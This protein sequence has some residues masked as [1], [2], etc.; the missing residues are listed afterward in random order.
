MAPPPETSCATS[1]CS[2]ASPEERERHGSNRSPTSSTRPPTSSSLSSAVPASRPSRRI[3][4]CCRVR[5]QDRRGV[6]GPRGMTCTATN[7]SALSVTPRQ[8][9]GPEAQSG[10]RLTAARTLPGRQAEG[11]HIN[12]SGATRVTLPIGRAWR[13]IGGYRA[14]GDALRS[15]SVCRNA[16]TLARRRCGYVRLPEAAGRRDLGPGPGMAVRG[17]LRT[18]SQMRAPGR[19]T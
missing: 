6:A 10:A 13:H 2:R 17:Q 11:A 7:P 19:P 4:R 18:S 9:R 12:H 3:L 1:P 8:L 16:V 5:R 15:Y 14:S